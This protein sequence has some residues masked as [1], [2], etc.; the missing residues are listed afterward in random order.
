MSE[1][2]LPELA[3][4]TTTS[5]SPTDFSVSIDLWQLSEHLFQGLKK[6][7][8]RQGNCSRCALLSASPSLGR[9]QSPRPRCCHQPARGRDARG[10]PS[11]GGRDTVSL[12]G[13]PLTA[14]TALPPE[15]CKLITTSASSRWTEKLG[16]V[17][18]S[19]RTSSAAGGKAKR[20]ARALPAVIINYPLKAA[21]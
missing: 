4:R 18:Q 15:L 17:L 8:T 13:S 10:D 2:T 12:L 16:R 6:Q 21:I 7:P 14:P 1:V 5:S 3:L 9:L 11:P 20:T 19:E